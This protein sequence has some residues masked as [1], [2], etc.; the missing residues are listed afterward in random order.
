MFI[1]TLIVWS[2]IIVGWVV[3]C[4]GAWYVAARDDYRNLAAANACA[5]SHNLSGD[6]GYLRDARFYKSEVD[7]KARNSRLASAGG[8]MVV[9]V[10]MIVSRRRRQ[11][12]PAA[13]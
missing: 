2:S 9:C 3:I 8:A 11:G 7:R 6:C 4:S 12:R 1:R 5:E 10:L 13:L